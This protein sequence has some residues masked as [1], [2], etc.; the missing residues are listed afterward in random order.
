MPPRPLPRSAGGWKSIWYTFS[1]AR[2]AGGVRGF[3]RAMRSKNACKT[4]A[5]GMGGQ[6]GGMTNEKGHFPEVCK[7]SVQAMA[8]DMQGK[9]REGFFRE[10]DFPKLERLSPREMEF[11]GRITEPLYAG[12]GDA[13]YRTISWDEALVRVATAM[14]A[15]HPDETFFYF[16]GRSSN[17][18]AFLLQVTAR[19]YGTNNVNNCSFFCHQAS[20]VAMASA[21]GSGTATITLEDLDRCDFV[22]LLGGNPASNHPRLMRTILDLRRRGGKVVVVNPIRE[23]GLMNFAVPS[24]VRSLLFG[25]LMN[26]EYVM[27]HIG[28]DI[29][30]MYGVAK[31][32]LGM[33]GAVDDKYL[34]DH[35]EGAAEFRA[36]AN[37]LTWDEIERGSG[38]TREQIEK[39]ARMYAASKKAVFCW[40]MGMTHHAHGVDNVRMIANL[41]LL[42]GM[43]GRE[44]AGLLP[45]R[46]HSNV[47]GV[48]SMGVTPALKDQMLRAIE[49]R[50]GVKLPT[51][52]GLDTLGC[53]HKAASGGVKF[54]MHLGGNL[55]GSCPDAA[56]ARKAL[57][58]IGMTVFMS[59]TLNT[60]HAS[61][62]GRESIILPVRARDEEAQPTTQESMFNYVRYSEGGPARHAGP[63]GEVEVIAA[64]AKRVLGSTTPLDFDALEKHSN[65]REAI[66][67]IVPGYEQA[68]AMDKHKD[69]FHVKGRTFHEP[70]FAL[71]GGRAKMHTVEVPLLAGAPDEFRLMTIRSEGQ[72]NTVV[73]EEEDVYRGQERRDIIL[74]NQADIDRLG[75]KED[76]R[77][78]V[79]SAVG[80]MDN[81]LIRPFD[82]RA[83]NAAMYCP[84]ANVLVPAK[85]DPE[86]RT[87]SF[88]NVAVRVRKHISL[89]VMAA[90]PE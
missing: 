90:R 32:L 26:D 59:T 46:G 60:G 9:I 17:E 25:S 62:R 34:N 70:K 29:A 87:P 66:A 88:K 2:E 36:K 47:Q 30:F 28:G 21:I 50:F 63:R 18:A 61:G 78:S 71:P 24:D 42:R 89:P 54:A 64:I 22:M 58:Q 55:F 67:A 10:F 49:D 40:T 15:A 5:L 35:T 41:A 83:G 43:V 7:K 1:K 65:L 20:G 16:S 3:I 80:R 73:Y 38:V 51:S 53:V 44:G 77:V 13:S 11:A 57:S 39:V 33:T 12:P 76:D 52:K 84:E 8:A 31:A 68:A 56:A 75:L 6:R 19:L 4:C 14:K 79:V 72:F 85:I 81:I 27:P 45:L 86:S 74:M 23:R 48:G 82:I 37:A 69:E